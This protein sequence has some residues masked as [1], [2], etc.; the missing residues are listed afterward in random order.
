MSRICR[1][2]F[3]LNLLVLFSPSCSKAG[4]T[5]VL[6]ATVH[7]CASEQSCKCALFRASRFDKN[8]TRGVR[9]DVESCCRDQE[10]VRW[11]ATHHATDLFSYGYRQSTDGPTG[12]H[13]TRA[14]N[15]Q[16]IVRQR[17]HLITSL[18]VYFARP[19]HDLRR[20]VELVGVNLID[21]FQELHVSKT[22]SNGREVSEADAAIFHT[23]TCY[24]VPT[25]THLK[26]TG[27]PH[28]GGTLS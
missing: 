13:R 3:S 28:S 6:S 20:Y 23:L 19:R 11:E 5:T 4:V 17:P 14:T 15:G 22:S 21:F 12:W 16:Q 7:A 9:G 10:E 26:S 2:I 27:L 1:N 25:M 18:T 24:R 8:H